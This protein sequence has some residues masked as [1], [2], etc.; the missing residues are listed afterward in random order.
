MTRPLRILRNVAIALAALIVVLAI[1]GVLVV[2]SAWFQNYV[3]QTIVT[4]VEDSTGGK[5]EI[6]AFHF[7]WTHLSAV[8]DGFRDSWN[9]GGGRL[10]PCFEW[11]EC[12]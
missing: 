11:R 2:R 7:D 6:G 10:R 12:S 9:R 3:K 8:A 4:S 5:V 1:T